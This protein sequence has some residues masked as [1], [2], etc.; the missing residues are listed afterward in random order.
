WL[1]LK[2]S[3]PWTWCI[4]GTPEALE[5]HVAEYANWYN[6]ERPHAALCGA[7]PDDKRRGRRRRARSVPATGKWKLTVDWTGPFRD[8]PIVRLRKV[9]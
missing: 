1:S 5:R 7:T 9:A 2:S 4:F 6:T 3:I 8:L